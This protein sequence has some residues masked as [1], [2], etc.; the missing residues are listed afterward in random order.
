MYV[1]AGSKDDAVMHGVYVGRALSVSQGQVT[2]EAWAGAVSAVVGG[3]TG[4][5]EP[6]RQGAV[7]EPEKLDEAV[8]EAER[9]IAERL[10]GLQL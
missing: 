3:K 5:K 10:A 6:S 1:F 4:G 7:T 9:W 2:A 8:A